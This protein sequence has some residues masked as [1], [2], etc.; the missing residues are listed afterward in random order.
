MA[1]N[2]SNNNSTKE[3]SDHQDRALNLRER[4]GRDRI[5]SDDY[6]EMLD[7]FCDSKSDAAVSREKERNVGY[8]S[9]R[10]HARTTNGSHRDGKEEKRDDPKIWQE[11]VN[12]DR[13]NGKRIGDSDA[14]RDSASE[15]TL[16]RP[17]YN[18]EAELK[19]GNEAKRFGIDSND[20]EINLRNN[21]TQNAEENGSREEGEMDLENDQRSAS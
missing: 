17:K 11:F 1:N 15:A 14:R 7:R 13:T 4:D 5:E 16:K 9:E 19:S 8:D 3:R 2:N 12:S 6:Q 20:D 10:N 18:H 21:R